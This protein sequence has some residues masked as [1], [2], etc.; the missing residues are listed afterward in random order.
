MGQTTESTKRLLRFSVLAGY[1]YHWNQVMWL[2]S[3]SVARGSKL[4][5][6]DVESLKHPN[7]ITYCQKQ[8]CSPFSVIFTFHFLFLLWV[9]LPQTESAYGIFQFIIFLS[10]HAQ[11]VTWLY[12]GTIGILGSIIIC[13]QGYSAKVEGFG[14]YPLAA[15]SIPQLWK[16]N[17]SPDIVKS[18]QAKA[19]TPTSQVENYCFRVWS[20]GTDQCPLWYRPW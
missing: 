13:C 20:W 1:H 7:E 10:T 17:M 16:S 4:G 3:V 6:W 14:L 12:L 11:I 9:L 2:C 8:V 15:G 18:P 5:C 19:K